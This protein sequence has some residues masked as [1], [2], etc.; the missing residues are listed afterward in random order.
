MVH[1]DKNI[2]N[3]KAAVAFDA[4]KKAYGMLDT[5]VKFAE[6]AQVVTASIQ[7]VEAEEKNNK[8]MAKKEGRA[9]VFPELEQLEI[10]VQVMR[11]KL[12]GEMENR[13]RNMEERE[14]N[15]NARMANAEGKDKGEKAKKR[16]LEKQWELTRDVRVSSWRDF[17]GGK[18]GKGKKKVKP[19]KF[20]KPP[21]HEMEDRD[22]VASAEKLEGEDRDDIRHQTELRNQDHA[23]FKKDWR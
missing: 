7:R 16:K 15:A 22:S 17:L 4:V 14:A 11:T 18:A 20:F 5:E 23:A 19:P 2:G 12:F 10:A 3:E 1:P 21:S 8:K 9:Y 13:R 6:M